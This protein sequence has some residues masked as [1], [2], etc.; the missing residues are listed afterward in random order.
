MIGLSAILALLAHPLLAGTDLQVIRIGKPEQKGTLEAIKSNGDFVLKTSAGMEQIPL[1]EVVEV[2]LRTGEFPPPEKEAQLRLQNG[3]RLS[4][5]VIG[6]TKDGGGLIF[7]DSAFGRVEFGD[8]GLIRWILFPPLKSPPDLPT[9]REATDVVFRG[10]KGSITGSVVSFGRDSLDLERIESKITL[11]IPFD[12]VQG[13]YVSPLKKLRP[14]K[15]LLAVLTLR[16]GDVLTGSIRGITQKTLELSLAASKGLWIKIPL[17]EV[18]TIGVRNG[19][20]VF[21]SDLTPARIKENPWAFDPPVT[22]TPPFEGKVIYNYRRDRSYAGK[23]LRINGRTY[24]K[25]IGTH[26]WT[27]IE[28]D[29]GGNYAAFESRIGIDDSAGPGN[30]SVIFKVLVD[31]KPVYQSPVMIGGGKPADVRVNLKDAKRLVLLV[32]YTH[33]LLTVKDGREEDH[34]LDRADWVAARLIKKP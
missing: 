14:P 11:K 18:V 28:Y 25:G 4:G 22:H 16:N 33:E 8:F 34:V 26:S 24:L 15:D 20:F 12:D 2:L 30:G 27:E 17:D 1:S 13:V 9:S 19:R 31:G 5:K 23:P 21:L 6:G 3:D 29:L 7:E 10:E 32:D